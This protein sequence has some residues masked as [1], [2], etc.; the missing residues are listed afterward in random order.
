LL[1][2]AKRIC[3]YSVRY[4]N[5]EGDGVQTPKNGL[6]PAVNE[7]QEQHASAPRWAR[8]AGS[9]AALLFV[10]VA[11][12]VLGLAGPHGPARHLPQGMLAT[13]TDWRYF[14]LL[15]VLFLAAL[16]LNGERLSRF[17]IVSVPASAFLQ[18]TEKIV[19]IGPR[20]IMSSSLRKWVLVAHV[21]TSVGAAGAVAAFLVLSIAGSV[22]SSMLL[23]Q[24]C[25]MAN[26]LIAQDL[27]L[28]LIVSAIAIGVM[29]A[30]T[31]PWGL[32][33]H[34]WILVKLYM[35]IAIWLVLLIQLKNISDLATALLAGN[36]AIQGIG[37][38]KQSQ[39]IHAIAGLV[40]LVA[41]VAISFVKP[42]GL[43]AYG[44][45]HLA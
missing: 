8:L 18:M 14:A 19:E 27:I 11:A 32:I 2:T 13:N 31:T 16:T 40:S 3:H 6:L 12:T 10:F 34:Y 33:R 20:F 15:L 36:G 42:R 17:K 28:P 22:T 21:T 39:L 5:R 29:Q 25:Y 45:L 7:P 4:A 35:T 44:R 24:A 23:A 37:P 43:T 30:L 9:L 41:I 38:L 26:A 1:L